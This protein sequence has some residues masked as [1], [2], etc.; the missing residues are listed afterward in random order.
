MSHELRTPMNAIIGYSE[1]LAEEF[2]GEGQ[3]HYL[4]DIAKIRAA[5]KHLLSLIN[6]IL[7]LSKI[8]SG[9]MDLLLERFDLTEM[10]SETIATAQPLMDAR[11]VGFETVLAEDL[12][13]VRA[14]LTKLR[15][16]VLNLLSNAA[17]FT[18]EGSVEL[19]AEPFERDGDRWIRIAVQDTGIGIEADKLEHVFGEF[20]QAD[21]S[22][23]RNYGG[24]GLGLAISRRFCRM[25][26]GDITAASVVGEGS[27]FT[28]EI[29]ASVDALE[30]ARSSLDG[31]VDEHGT[32]VPEGERPLVLIVEDDPDS[33]DLLVRMLSGDGFRV[34]TAQDGEQGLA[35]AHELHPDL[36]TLDVMMPG[37]D[38]W[39]MLRRVKAGDD[40]CNIP[41]VMV[42]IVG[43]KAMG[44]ALGASDYLQKPVDRRALLQSVR[45]LTGGGAAD[46]LVVEDDKDTRELLRRALEQEGMAVR[47]AV[48]GRMALAGVAESQPG[49]ILLD[50][51]MPVMDGFEFLRRLRQSETGRNVPVIVLTAKVLSDEEIRELEA[52]TIEVLSKQAADER[53]IIDE[54]RSVL[55]K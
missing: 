5:G 12:G 17:K 25:M 52:A 46:V 28:I 45:R 2:E 10:L 42:T 40:T 35:L 29:P 37:M 31:P 3:E 41:I 49:L 8:E 20:T 21:R 14:D 7:D 18:H 9:R 26:G 34:A 23:T 44:Q 39:G 19:E 33:R 27:K 50:L 32:Q 53:T 38:G 24:T 54:V 1:M 6:D 51:M 48:D 11:G 22:T 43:D 16:V 13:V 4:S 15:Q 47:E 30:A 55:E 36:I